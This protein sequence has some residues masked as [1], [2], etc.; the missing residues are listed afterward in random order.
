MPNYFRPNIAAMT[1][2]IPGEQPQDPGFIKLNTNENPYPPSPRVKAALK[3]AVNDSLRLYPEPLADTL[4]ETAAGAYGVKP[5]NIIAGNGS[6]ELLSIALR[7]FVG[8]GDRVAFPRPTYTLYDTLLEIQ[9]GVCAAVDYPEDFSLPAGMAGQNARVTFLCN[10]NAPSGT[11]LPLPEVE[12]LARALPGVLVVDEAYVDFAASEG[13]TALPLIGRLENLIV[14]RSFSKSFSLA[15]MRIGLAFAS[16][17][18]ISG[19]MKVKDSYNLNRLS[20]IAA[21]AALQD[22]RWMMRNAGRIQKS[23]KKL[24][25]GLKRLGYAVYPSHANFVLARKPGTDA[26]AVYEALKRRM[27]LVRHFDTTGLRDCLRIT[28]GTPKEIQ[29]VL[30]E[31]AALQ[32]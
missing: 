26:K 24:S 14:L 32:I 20:L 15:G 30:E 18:I 23:R 19:M 11:L 31:L 28:I 8:P 22:M 2:Y 7:C 29:R 16:E 9:D 13:C 27:I 6:D 12:R 4:R 25:T 17:G 1:G 10:P 5:A 3:K 21:T